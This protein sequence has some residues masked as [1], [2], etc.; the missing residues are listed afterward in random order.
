MTTPL[1]DYDDSWDEDWDGTGSVTRSDPFDDNEW[2]ES[3]A[4]SVEERRSRPRA[5]W[6]LATRRWI[7]TCRQFLEKGTCYHVYSFR[8]ET[9][10]KPN[11]EYL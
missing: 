7:C 10:V 8:S 6:D 1:D 3:W 2:A 11:E 5:H 9:V 4:Y